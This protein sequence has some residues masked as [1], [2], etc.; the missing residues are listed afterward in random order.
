MR[1]IARAG[2]SPTAPYGFVHPAG[3]APRGT[4]TPPGEAAARTP[5]ARRAW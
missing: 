4:R 3:T 5:A 2:R 1:P